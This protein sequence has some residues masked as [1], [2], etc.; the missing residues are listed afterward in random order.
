MS[1]G[2]CLSVERTKLFCTDVLFMVVGT[3]TSGFFLFRP[4]LLIFLTG[5]NDEEDDDDDDDDDDDAEESEDVEFALGFFLFRP[6][7]SFFFVGGGGSTNTGDVS[8][9]SSSSLSCDA[10][11][12]A[13]RCSS[14]GITSCNSFPLSLNSTSMNFPDD[15]LVATIISDSYI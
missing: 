9:F 12:I 11:A 7:V 8:W 2:V 15:L 1:V 5:S 10:R 13:A 3:E 4:L 6:L 14:I